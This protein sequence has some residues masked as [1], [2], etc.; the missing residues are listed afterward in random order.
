MAETEEMSIPEIVRA[1]M[2]ATGGNVGVLLKIVRKQK[3]YRNLDEK[4]IKGRIYAARTAIGRKP[5]VSTEVVNNG[6]SQK[7]AAALTESGNG[8]GHSDEL[9]KAA[10]AESN[11]PNTDPPPSSPVSVESPAIRFAAAM[12]KI[13]EGHAEL[14]ALQSELPEIFD[15]ADRFAAASK[16]FEGVFGD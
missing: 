10:A 6:T 4:I 12:K 2:E 11:S 7:E 3:Q 14:E 9:Q 1:N 16:H 5:A 8:T 13:R 15:H